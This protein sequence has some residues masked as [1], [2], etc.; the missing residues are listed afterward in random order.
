MLVKRA[1]NVAAGTMKAEIA[2][3]RNASIGIVASG[4]V[5]IER[6]CV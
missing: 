4:T 1:A 5:S 3:N 2:R 6:M